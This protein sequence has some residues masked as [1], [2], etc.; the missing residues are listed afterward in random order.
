[1]KVSFLGLDENP[2]V[3]ALEEE[4]DYEA[5]VLSPVRMIFLLRCDIISLPDKVSFFKSYN[6][7]VFVHVDLIQGLGND[8]MA[9]QYVHQ[10]ARPDGII[11]TKNN[12]VKY[13]R[14][15]GLSTIQR[16]FAVDSHAYASA[17]KTIEQTQPD[18]VEIMPG[19]IPRVIRE[20]SMEIKKPII[21]GGLID[22]K[23]DIISVLGAGAVGISTSK[24]ALWNIK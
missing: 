10:N 17:V 21:A 9:I 16:F 15:L 1:M 19:I 5:A 14:E 4:K 23:E 22:C 2:I 13:G 24:E 8:Q 7:T 20:L 11:T 12:I 3:A 18:A 6:K